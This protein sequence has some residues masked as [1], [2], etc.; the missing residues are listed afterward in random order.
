MSY[1]AEIDKHSKT[2][3]SQTG[4]DIILEWLLSM[5][6]VSMPTYLDIGANHP[7]ALSNTFRFYLAGASGLLVE[8]NPVLCEQLAKYR[9]RD[10]RLNV[11]IGEESGSKAD[12]YVMNFDALSTLSRESA[13]N[14]YRSHTGAKIEKIIQVPVF[15]IN[16]VLAQYFSKVRLD[17]LSLDA[18]GYDMQILTAMD[19]Q[20]YR[21]RTIIVETIID[22]KR[23]NTELINLILSK[24]YNIFADTYIN[25]IFYSK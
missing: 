24:G 25:T 9:P 10:V 15:T 7:I 22:N 8:P 17:V 23:K 11:A 20:Q 4:E 19:F 18:E 13:E 5:L 21:P 12:F 14:A 2:S 3:F 6:G 16:D 1:F